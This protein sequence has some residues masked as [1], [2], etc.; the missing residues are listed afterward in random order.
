MK[1]TLGTCYYP[2]HWP[3]DIWAEDA[4]RMAQ[5]GLTWVR[6][7]EFAWSRIEP[8]PDAL[9]WDWLDQAIE[10]LG[11]A[12]LKVVLGTPTA[13]PPKW[14]LDKHP[15]MLAV[16]D[17]GRPRK[18][19]SRRHYC[20]SHAG[21]LEECRRIVG[22]IA[23]RYGQNHHVAAW[24]TDNEYGCHDTTLSYSDAARLGF[25][26]WLR[27]QFSAQGQNDGIAAL[28]AAWGNVFWSM[29]YN[30]VDDIDLPNLTVTDPNPSHVLAFHRY[31]SDQV[32]A[33]NRAQV[34]IIRAH[35]QA[36]VTHNYMGR[37]TDFDHFKVG[38]DLD[39]ASWD[40]Y[41][42][43]FLEDRVGA[44][45]EQ[46]RKFANQGHPDFQAFHHDLYRAVG[47]GRWWVM[48]Q[49]PGPVNWAPYNPSPLP[50][51]VRLWSWEAF[52]HG[53]EAVC[54]FRWRQ[55]P[56]A[57]EQMH[58]GM[59]RPDSVD[60]PAI[61][62]ARQVAD[63]LKQAPEVQMVQASV[64]LIFDY[65]ADWAWSVQPQ[66][67]GLSYFGLI[68]DHYRALRRAGLSVD[69]LPAHCRDFSGYDL[70]LAP[71]MMHMPEDLKRALS[72]GNAQV[73]I[74]PRS[75][76]RNANMAIPVPLPPAFPGL[77]VTVSRVETLRPDRPV[78]LT[79]GGAITGYLE[80]LEGTADIITQTTTGAAVVM[81]AGLVTYMGGWGDDAALDVLI[82]DLCTRAGLATMAL[83]DGV[84]IR[85]T[86][87]ERFWF[88]YNAEP[89]ATEAG[90]L[91]AAGVLR[92]ELT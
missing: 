2:E 23:E 66:G 56:F 64:A 7:G 72:G 20:F 30:D 48:E 41:P 71:G 8:T 68:F 26:G 27:E 46:Q 53:A 33:F 85:D 13:T 37:I 70:V 32:V 52:A 83:P 19:G 63:E 50:G 6:I 34:E 21:Y 49:Q 91:P 51:M 61:H 18:F 1:R 12:G 57:Q 22:L 79:S 87:T 9:T 28:N 84:R 25:R 10:T 24:Q 35:S 4:R 5:A 76:A 59:L 77:D 88:N 42:L 31:T 80:E 86:A 62:E 15:D 29:E 89:I 58:A 3:S 90:V 40:S 67:A 47:R 39:I 11:Q 55:A 75:A 65:D 17:Q 74:G 82:S 38:A 14:V 16:D 60:A 69:I 73:L 43:G 81:R 36:P 92:V 45:V 78:A 54:Y 44:S